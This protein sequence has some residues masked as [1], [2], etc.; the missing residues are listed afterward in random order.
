MRSSTTMTGRSTSATSLQDGWQVN[1]RDVWPYWS[2]ESRSTPS[3]TS[4]SFT[5]ASCPFL[6]SHW[7]DGG[8]RGSRMTVEMR[9][10][11]HMSRA[12]TQ[13]L[14]FLRAHQAVAFQESA[15]RPLLPKTKYDNLNASSSNSPPNFSSPI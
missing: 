4:S 1:D 8:G 11:E 14:T 13:R 3:V 5:T 9:Q 7:V 10:V 2:L 15:R 6:R 12:A